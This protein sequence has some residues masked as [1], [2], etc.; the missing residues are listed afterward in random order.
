MFAA[1]KPEIKAKFDEIKVSEGKSVTLPCEV[2]GKPTPAK[3]WK[4]KDQKMEGPGYVMKPTGSLVIKVK[5]P[6]A[7]F[8]YK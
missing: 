4:R 7:V 1:Y 6:V 5:F 3:F 2:D 8:R